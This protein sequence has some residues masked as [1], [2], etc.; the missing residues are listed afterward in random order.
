MLVWAQRPPWSTRT[1]V[2][3]PPQLILL[4]PRSFYARAWNWYVRAVRWI[5]RECSSVPFSFRDPRAEIYREKPNEKSILVGNFKE[6]LIFHE[7]GR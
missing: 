3:R 5:Q 2:R 4:L 1:R 7:K 6:P